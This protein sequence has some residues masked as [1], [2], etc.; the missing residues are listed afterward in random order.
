RIVD[1]LSRLYDATEGREEDEE[2]QEEDELN[3]MFFV[4]AN[5]IHGLLS[6]SASDL[7]KR[8]IGDLAAF[9]SEKDPHRVFASS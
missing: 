3:Y 7:A 8:A 9:V 4:H 5:H 6:A 2:I 1:F